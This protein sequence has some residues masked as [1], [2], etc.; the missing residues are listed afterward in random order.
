MSARHAVY[1]LYILNLVTVLSSPLTGTHVALSIRGDVDPQ[2]FSNIKNW[3]AI[4]DSYAAGIGAGDILKGNGDSSCSRYDNAYP[5]MLNQYFNSDTDIGDREFQFIACSGAETP[6]IIQQVASLADSSQDLVTVS[7]GGNDVGF[8]DVLIACVY[9]LASD[10]DC[11]AAFDEARTKILRSLTSNVGKLLTSLDQKLKPGG[12]V[13]YTLY[14]SFFNAATDICDDKTWSF[15]DPFK[16]FGPKL[17]KD[18]RK[19]MNSLVQL[20]NQKIQ[21]AVNAMNAK[22]TKNVATYVVADY[23]NYIGLVNGRF[24]EDGATTNISDFTNR[25]EMLQRFNDGPA[26]YHSDELKLKRQ[27]PASVAASIKA[28][29]YDSADHA[30]EIQKNKTMAPSHIQTSEKA[31]LDGIKRVFH[32]NEK[33]HSV[34]AQAAIA[35]YIGQRAEDLNYDS[36]LPA[37]CNLE[38]GKPGKL[39]CNG[40]GQKAYMDYPDTQALMIQACSKD[41]VRSDANNGT[42]TVTGAGGQVDIFLDPR[43][44]NLTTD[45]CRA[46]VGQIIGNCDEP[47]SD[48]TNL[49]LLN[50]K[51]GGTYNWPNGEGFTRL[52][53]LDDAHRSVYCQN[54]TVSGGRYAKS[55]DMYNNIDAFCDGIGPNTN[56][57]GMKT[58]YLAGSASDFEFGVYAGGPHQFDPAV[59]KSSMKDLLDSCNVDPNNPLSYR[60]AGSLDFQGMKYMFHSNH[61]RALPAYTEPIGECW[62]WYKFLYAETSLYGGGWSDGDWGGAPSGVL[63]QMR[64]CGPVTGWT[65]DYFQAP[66]SNRYEWRSSFSLPIGTRRCVGRAMGSAGG[67]QEKGCSGSG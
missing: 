19:S 44:A 29:G 54:A 35:A 9:T 56:T 17:T 43:T 30:L 27:I 60:Y 62:S 57:F 39:T 20:A 40:Y 10:A 18:K 15:L 8:S 4:G 12:I 37:S 61:V 31:L 63:Q 16:T 14:A 26:P 58:P 50:H 41:I 42:T 21:D 55:S 25:N 33:G 22:S 46:Y 59:C 51:Y 2:D 23:D 34:I 52:T 49:N 64:G 38:F 6:E 24:C 3:T 36:S 11:A 53:P 32:P 47:F 45:D 66:D 65:F 28:Q 7:A 48:V 5:I 1:L 13:V 67:P